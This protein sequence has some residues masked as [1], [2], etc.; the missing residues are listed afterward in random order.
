MAGRRVITPQAR[1]LREVRRERG[2]SLRELSAASLVPKPTLSQ[3]EN[4]L[5]CPTAREQRLL[6]AAL[7][8]DSYRVSVR[9]YLVIE[10]EV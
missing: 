4:G 5:R 3:I 8:I 7:G 1:L 10:E 2:L 6:A 9:S